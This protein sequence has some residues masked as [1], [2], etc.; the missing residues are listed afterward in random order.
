MTISLTE[1]IAIVAALQLFI[2]SCFLI[3]L[4]KGNRISQLL[5]SGFLFT[6]AMFLAGYLL[7]AFSEYILPEGAHFFFIGTSFGFLFGPLL[8][9][10]TRSLVQNNFQLRKIQLLHIIPFLI[11]NLLYAIYYHFEPVSVKIQMI[12]SG[13]VLPYSLGFGL[14]L[15]MNI[16]ILIYMAVTIFLLLNYSRTIKSLYSTIQHLNLSWLEL[17]L[18]AFLL[19]W[20][21]DFAHFLF[22]H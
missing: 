19:M 14:I 4:K 11:Y 5:L 16:Q 17:V 12:Q 22:R 1:I 10:Y 18:F 13:S 8:L 7:S 6:N 21:I 2:F 3:S 9:L 15:L 20:V